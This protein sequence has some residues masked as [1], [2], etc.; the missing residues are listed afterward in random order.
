MPAVPQ[1]RT[2]APA[3]GPRGGGRGGAGAAGGRG[4][5]PPRAPVHVRVPPL[6]SLRYAAFSAAVSGGGD[7]GAARPASGGEAIDSPGSFRVPSTSSFRPGRVL[8]DRRP[9]DREPPVCRCAVAPVAT[10]HTVPGDGSRDAAGPLPLPPEFPSSRRDD[11]PAPRARAPRGG[12]RRAAPAAAAAGAGRCQLP[13]RR[14]QAA[15]GLLP[16]APRSG[17]VETTQPVAGR[18]AGPRLQPGA[19]QRSAADGTS[20]WRDVKLGVAVADPSSRASLPRPPPGPQNSAASVAR[21]RP[22][23]ATVKGST[24]RARSRTRPY[25]VVPTI[26][27]PAGRPPLRRARKDADHQ[28]RRQSGPDGRVRRHSRRRAA[29]SAAW[30]RASSKKG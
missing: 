26:L 14:R 5:M 7:A 2:R 23:P 21:A 10:A 22:R 28:R 20:Q 9:G 18:E 13:A 29:R 11:R 1:R 25:V 6:F 17:P 4:W 3:G 12:G 8:V 24:G 30:E 16:S 15:P 19:R 27:T